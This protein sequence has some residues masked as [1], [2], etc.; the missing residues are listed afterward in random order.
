MKLKFK[1]EHI[2]YAMEPVWNNI[3]FMFKAQVKPIIVA[4]SEKNFEQEIEVS[5]DILLEIYKGVSMQPNGIASAINKEIKE[6]L[7][8]QLL[9]ESNN[10]ADNPNEA[11]ST[12]LAIQELDLSYIIDR[13]AL[14]EKGKNKILE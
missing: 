6:V 9:S 2:H 1:N 7:L 11:F 12:I 13:E 10:D 5:K 4:N 14:I 8:T 3:D